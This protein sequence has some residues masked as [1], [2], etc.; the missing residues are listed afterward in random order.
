MF[1]ERQRVVPIATDEMVIAFLGSELFVLITHLQLKGNHPISIT[2]TATKA[3][4]NRWRIV[5]ALRRTVLFAD[6][7]QYIDSDRK[8]LNCSRC[9]HCRLLRQH[10]PLQIARIDNWPQN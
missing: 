7:P 8:N 10:S 2:G 3:D 1:S 6:S 5:H 4:K 9:Q